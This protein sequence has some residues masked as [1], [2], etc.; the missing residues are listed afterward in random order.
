MEKV[1]KALFLALVLM[2]SAAM[3]V[4]QAYDLARSMSYDLGINCTQ[5]LVYYALAP[6]LMLDTIVVAVYFFFCDREDSC[7]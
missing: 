6:I 2:C 1:I 5:E 3:N 4:A 7:V